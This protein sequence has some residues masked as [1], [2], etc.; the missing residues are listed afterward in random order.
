MNP[1]PLVATPRI[2]PDAL[3][4][5]V[6]ISNPTNVAAEL[7]NLYRNEWLFYNDPR[8]ESVPTSHAAASFFALGPGRAVL[9]QG[10]S[11]GG[12]MPSYSVPTPGWSRIEPGR[13]MRYTIVLPTPLREWNIGW[14]ASRIPADWYAGSTRISEMVLVVE[15]RFVQ[16]PAAG[17]YLGCTFALPVPQEVALMRA[18]LSPFLSNTLGD[19]H[20]GLPD[21]ALRELLRG[22]FPERGP[23]PTG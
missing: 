19:V 14:Q 12:P 15:Y 7:A 22:P 3:A 4:I 13:E 5:D 21:L 16:G 8:L 20:R 1:L 23:A 2:T 10:A 6:C 11:G 17:R 18:H 9:Q